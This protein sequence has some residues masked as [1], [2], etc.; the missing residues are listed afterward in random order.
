MRLLS[1]RRVMY[2]YGWNR[3]FPLLHLRQPFIIVPLLFFNVPTESGVAMP[4]ILASA[5]SF[6]RSIDHSAFVPGRLEKPGAGSNK[7]TDL[8]EI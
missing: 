7:R 4:A 3:G 6:C 1:G 8:A 2:L 5:T